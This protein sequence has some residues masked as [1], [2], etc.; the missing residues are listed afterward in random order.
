MTHTVRSG[1]CV[2][3]VTVTRAG[4][5]RTPARRRDAQLPA[6]F[7]HSG[8]GRK[9]GVWL[10]A[11]SAENRLTLVLSLSSDGLVFDRHFVVRDSASAKPIRF[12]GGGKS[13]GFQYPGGMWRGDTMIMAYSEGKENISVTSFKLAALQGGG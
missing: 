10:I 11:N 12:Q 1:R 4:R 9:G 3:M 2:H 6:D 7:A 13:P 8:S 5:R